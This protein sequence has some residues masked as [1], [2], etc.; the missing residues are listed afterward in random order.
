[1]GVPG[2]LVSL[3]QFLEGYSTVEGYLATLNSP[4]SGLLVMVKAN[5]GRDYVSKIKQ[6]NFI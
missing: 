2:A 5:R 6:I 1:M 3:V 4:L